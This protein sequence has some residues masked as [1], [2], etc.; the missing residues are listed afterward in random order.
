MAIGESDLVAVNFFGVFIIFFGQG[1]LTFG[2]DEFIDI[3]GRLFVLETSF[4]AILFGIFD[5]IFLSDSG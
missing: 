2:D 4:D 5:E 3:E 1:L